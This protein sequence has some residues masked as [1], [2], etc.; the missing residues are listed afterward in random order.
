MFVIKGK[1]F[2]FDFM[3][4]GKYLQKPPVLIMHGRSPMIVTFNLLTRSWPGEEE[5]VEIVFFVFRSPHP[6][7]QY[8]EE[9][10]DEDEE[11][12]DHCTERRTGK[13]HRKYNYI[14]VSSIHSTEL[15]C[16]FSVF[17]FSTHSRIFHS[18]E[19]IIFTGECLHV[20]T[21][22]RK[23]MP[24]NLIIMTYKSSEY[25]TA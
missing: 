7:P 12:D 6:T 22:A 3:H 20:F 18:Y 23:L 17:G 10:E 8:T 14:I 15:F 21:Y 19:D 2:Q 13:N 25:G 11:D 4:D 16:L 1:I 9:E 5:I 24:H